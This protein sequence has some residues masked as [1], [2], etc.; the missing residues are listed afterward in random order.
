MKAYLKNYRQSPRKVRLVADLIKGKPVQRAILLLDT[1]PKRATAQL[2]KLVRSAISNAK[3]QGMKVEDLIVKEIRVDKGLTMHRFMPKA[4]GR[5]TRF[6]KHSSNIIL[7]LADKN[8]ANAKSKNI[9]KKFV[10]STGP[11]Q[12]TQSV[13]SEAPVKKA[14]KKAPAKKKAVTSK[15][16]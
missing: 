4:Q 6:D 7:V 12:K 9:E 15:K 14:T 11:K 1:T 16:S 10:W 5:A 8:S 3:A 2:S 13:E